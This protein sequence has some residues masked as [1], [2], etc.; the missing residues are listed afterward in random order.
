MNKVAFT[1]L[2]IVTFFSAVAQKKKDWKKE[3]LDQSGDHVM[4]QFGYEKWT[5]A[6]DS[7][8]NYMKG[9]PRGINIAVMYNKPFKADPRWSVAL[10]IGVSSSNIFFKS[11]SADIAAKGNVLPFSRLDSSQRFK[12]FKLAT[13]YAEIPL[14]LRYTLNP[15]DQ[16][17]SWKFAVG[18]K[19]GLL[20]DAH[21]K[22]KTLQDKNGAALNSY[23]EKIKKRTFFNGSRIAATARIGYGN[24][25]LFGTYTLS[26]LLK[27]G[28]GAEI[29][30]FQIGLC[31]SGL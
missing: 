30:P 11:M 12:K 13:A 18:A 15:A 10:G 23:T 20:L 19:L 22:G 5:G 17:K 9:F 14:E 26:K 27:D 7:I 8:S 28:A 4:L 3:A 25:S 16:K 21:T 2:A 1:L 31:L 24:F 6:P 29:K